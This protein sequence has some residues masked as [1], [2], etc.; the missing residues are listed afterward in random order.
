ML[1]FTHAQDTDFDGYDHFHGPTFEI[2]N[3][4]FEAKAAKKLVNP[5][6]G[7]TYLTCAVSSC[8]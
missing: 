1:G 6:D 5:E 7:P 8:P 2:L 4:R 3:I